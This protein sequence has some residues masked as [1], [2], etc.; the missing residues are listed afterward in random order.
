M[1]QTEDKLQ[2]M[3]EEYQWTL[4]KVVRNTGVPYD[5]ID[6]V[7]Q[8]TFFAYYSHYS[9]DWEPNAK[10]AMLVRIA[11]NKSTDYFRKSKH[12]LSVSMDSDDYRDEMDILT[13]LVL[14]DTLDCILEDEA[15]RELYEFLKSLKKDW[16]NIAL[17]HFVEGRDVVE[18]AKIEGIK[19]SACRMRISRIRKYIRKWLEQRKS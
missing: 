11:K 14:K 3:Y 9:L 16:R 15:C 2:A 12:Y 6:D 7:I 18:V 1:Q 13:N 8:E 19:E 4:R 10:K 5:Y 17:L